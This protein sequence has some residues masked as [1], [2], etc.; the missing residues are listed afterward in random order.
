MV[1]TSPSYAFCTA[2]AFNATLLSSICLLHT[3]PIPLQRSL[4]PIA[5]SVNVFDLNLHD[6]V[7]ILLRSVVASYLIIGPL[8]FHGTISLSARRPPRSTVLHRPSKFL[9]LRAPPL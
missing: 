8:R 6:A 1:H 5:V 4:L 7:L 2:E 3:V 9:F